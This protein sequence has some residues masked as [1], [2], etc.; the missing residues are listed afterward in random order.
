MIDM[1]AALTA[2]RGAQEEKK[3]DIK[4]LPLGRLFKMYN[5][6]AQYTRLQSFGGAIARNAKAPVYDF[7][8]DQVQAEICRRREE[9]IED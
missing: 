2:A 5:D 8:F 3:Q 7:S 9:G 1:G 6:W 4:D